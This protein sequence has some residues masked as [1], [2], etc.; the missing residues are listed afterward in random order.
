MN[1]FV[2]MY[3]M[4]SKIVGLN[5]NR[6]VDSCGTILDVAHCRVS[7]VV[8]FDG[9]LICITSQDGEKPEPRIIAEIN[10]VTSRERPSRGVQS[11]NIRVYISWT[12]IIVTQT[13]TFRGYFPNCW[14]STRRIYVS[15]LANVCFNYLKISA[16]RLFFIN[17]ISTCGRLGR[18]RCSKK[19]PRRQGKRQGTK[20]P[21]L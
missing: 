2:R 19:N 21:G 12:W 9:K 8:L 4:L 14:N 20:G 6:S 13:N 11:C 18:P 17:R 5:N 16:N 10:T 3:T 1:L 15:M 7:N